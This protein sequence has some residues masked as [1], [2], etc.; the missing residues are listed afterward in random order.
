MQKSFLVALVFVMMITISL[1]FT[2]NDPGY[3]NLKILPKNITAQQMDSVMDHFSQA[4]G[5]SCDFCHVKSGDNMEFA[6]DDN[7]HK[8]VAREM[9]KMTD[10]I[11]DDYFDMTGSKRDLNTPLMVTC[12]TCHHGQT[13]PEV[14]PK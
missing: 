12:Y 14:K 8:L 5:V 2:K 4:L 1:A 9:M 3:K 11:N 7:K 13:Q 6:A 10:K